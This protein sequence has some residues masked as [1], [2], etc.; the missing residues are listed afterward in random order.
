MGRVKAEAE[1][2]GFN[3]EDREGTGAGGRKRGFT[4]KD[5]KDTKVEEGGERG[6][7]I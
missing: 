3:T 7:G 2:E 1:A 5:T 4:T 6:D